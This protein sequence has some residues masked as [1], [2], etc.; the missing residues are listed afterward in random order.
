MPEQEGIE[1]ILLL[2]RA[3]PNLKIIAMP[4]MFAGSLLEAEA[5]R[6]ARIDRQAGAAGWAIGRGRAGAGRILIESWLCARS[7][8]G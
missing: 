5:I 3:R 4:G 2:H 7:S 1:T 6:R 8:V